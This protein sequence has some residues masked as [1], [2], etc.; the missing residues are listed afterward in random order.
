LPTH[1]AQ[2]ILDFVVNVDPDISMDY[3]RLPVQPTGFYVRLSDIAAYKGKTRNLVLLRMISM[4]TM[5][6]WLFTKLE[7]D[8]DKRSA[9]HYIKWMNEY[10]NDFQVYGTEAKGFYLADP[11][12]TKDAEGK[13]IVP[14]PPAWVLEG[15]T[16]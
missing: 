11:K 15:T 16:V 14:L 1:A 6:Y 5:Y 7:D 12:A 10:K 13:K 3:T 4:A 2:D 8:Q 9:Y